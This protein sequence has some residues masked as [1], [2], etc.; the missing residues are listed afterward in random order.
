MK[1]QDLPGPGTYTVDLKSTI[2]GK[3]STSPR[4]LYQITESPGPGQYE[5]RPLRRSRILIKRKP[6]AT[7]KLKPRTFKPVN[8]TIQGIPQ[9]KRPKNKLYIGDHVIKN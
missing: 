5:A 2:R 7:A 3:F 4:Q 1:F 8:L 9:C 6:T